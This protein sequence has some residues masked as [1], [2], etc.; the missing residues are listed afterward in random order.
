MAAIWNHP[1]SFKEIFL[2]GIQAQLF[3]LNWFGRIA[4]V[5]NIF[6]N[7]WVPRSFWCATEIETHICPPQHLVSIDKNTKYKVWSE[8]KVTHLCLALCNPMDY[9]LH[10]ILYARI[11]EWVGSP[12]SRGSSQSRNW[13]QVSHIASRF[14]TS[15]ATREAQE[16][17]SG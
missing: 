12:F 11:L 17:W 6:Q 3:L 5:L 16:Y 2:S 1:G 10:G 15:W 7:P 13:T 8:L 14:F 9:T 4:G